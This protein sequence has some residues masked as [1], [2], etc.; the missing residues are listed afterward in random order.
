MQFSSW[1]LV[2][3]VQ[4]LQ[5]GGPLYSNGGLQPSGRAR[6]SR[7]GSGRGGNAELLHAAGAAPFHQSTDAVETDGGKEAPQ[8]ELW[9]S[10]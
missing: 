3:R 9:A 10:I 4:G 2:Y 6:G 8:E 5:R 7:A 1:C